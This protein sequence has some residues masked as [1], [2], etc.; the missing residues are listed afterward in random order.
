MPHQP[1]LFA[2][3][4]QLQGELAVVMKEAALS[5]GFSNPPSPSASSAQRNSIQFFSVSAVT[6]VSRRVPPCRHTSLKVCTLGSSDLLQATCLHDWIP[7][8][9]QSL[10]AKVRLFPKS[11]KICFLTQYLIQFLWCAKGRWNVRLLHTHTHPTSERQPWPSSSHIEV[12]LPALFT[13]C[14]G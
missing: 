7:N 8:L 12:F 9:S 14:S 5:A 1:L 13:W 6:V 3:L 11:W 4:P 2:Q 10:W